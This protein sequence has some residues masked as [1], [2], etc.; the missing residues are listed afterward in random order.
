MSDIFEIKDSYKEHEL[1]VRYMVFDNGTK[2]NVIDAYSYIYDT[3]VGRQVLRVRLKGE[4]TDYIRLYELFSKNSGTMRLHEISGLVGSQ[5]SI[6]T[7]LM[8]C[9]DHVIGIFNNYSKNLQMSYN[10]DPDWPECFSVEIEKVTDA[11]LQSKANN[12]VLST[13]TEAICELYE[14]GLD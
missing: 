9:E 11:E 7:G 10:S 2:V 12:E 1:P 8:T 4:P 5:P 3:G 14:A 6:E 13:A